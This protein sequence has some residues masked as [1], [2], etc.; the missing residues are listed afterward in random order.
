MFLSA[1]ARQK[2]KLMKPLNK[3]KAFVEP[4]G[5]SSSKLES[6]TPFF[7]FA[8]IIATRDG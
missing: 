6:E 8:A 1:H 7:S 5:I 3:R 2:Q 4:M